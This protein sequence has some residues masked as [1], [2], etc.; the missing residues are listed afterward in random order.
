MD[1][2]VVGRMALEVVVTVVVVQL[3]N[4]KEITLNSQKIIHIDPTYHTFSIG[5]FY[6]QYKTVF[7]AT[8]MRDFH[9]IY[10]E[11]E[12]T[13]VLDISHFHSICIIFVSTSDIQYENY[14]TCHF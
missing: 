10:I 2:L 6:S 7:Q 12:Y 8:V 5:Y 3:V 13:C 1:V 9:D 14:T 11:D 4:F